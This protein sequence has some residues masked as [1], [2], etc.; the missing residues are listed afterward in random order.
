MNRK[1][2][3]VPKNNPE[4]EYFEVRKDLNFNEDINTLDLVDGKK[5]LEIVK[6]DV[7][8]LEDLELMDYSLFVMQLKL[9][10]DELSTIKNHEEFKYY[11]NYF[12][13]STKIEIIEGNQT[14]ICYII[15]IID[16][17]QKFTLNKKFERNFKG[18]FKKGVASSAP[19]SEY[20]KRFI[21]YC[22][23]IVGNTNK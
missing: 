10:K 1:T 7:Y 8:F 13:E 21:E 16:Y 3:I 14:N 17:L 4:D 20:S 19:P 12:F 11:E 2:R 23:T 6:K 15:M 9:S 22:D 5:F 18:M